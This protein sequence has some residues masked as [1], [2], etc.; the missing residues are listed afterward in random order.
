MADT[1]IEWAVASRRLAGQEESGDGF[2]VVE[3]E[4]GTLLAVVDGLGH[5]YE[6]AVAS[7]EAVSVLTAEPESDLVE[8]M[9]ICHERLRNTR[10]A[11][12]A[13]A[14]F[15]KEE[16]TL[17]WLGVGDASAVLV[18]ATF[19]TRERESLFLRPGIV[20]QTLPSLSVEM[21]R[22]VPGDVLIMVTD[23]IRSAFVGG[24]EADRSPQQMADRLL[25]EY[26]RDCD[27]AL[28]LVACYVGVERA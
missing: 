16:P 28:V 22:V 13:L 18:R 20:G 8:L 4:R 17:T 3:S 19:A 5:G 9:G 10:G 23:G 24:L 2:A 14:R 11:V 25:E 6:A 26:G 12:I 7:G 1:L 21:L 15:S 27:D